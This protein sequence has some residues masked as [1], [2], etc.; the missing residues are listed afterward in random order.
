MKSP[1]KYYGGKS[2]MTDIIINNFPEE[3]EVYVEGFGG[4]AS[5]LLAKRKN[6]P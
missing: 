5:V 1:I 2:Y 6:T 4:G 3:Y